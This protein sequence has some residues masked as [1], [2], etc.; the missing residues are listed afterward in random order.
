MTTAQN[1][2]GFTLIE[3]LVV[4]SIIG[5][6]ASV[7]TVSL[8]EARV[9]ARDTHRL[10]QM[11][12]LSIA[13]ELYHTSNGFYPDEKSTRAHITYVKDIVGLAPEHIESLPEDPTQTGTSRYRYTADDNGYSL[14]IDLEGDNFT[15]CRYET[16]QP[17]VISWETNFPTC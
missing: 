5:L 6:L 17:G 15:W 4:I 2:R 1:N 16:G 13:L 11:K 8:N 7:V 9:K 14:L 3:L 12:Q 10:D